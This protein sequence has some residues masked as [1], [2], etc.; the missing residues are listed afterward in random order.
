M[1]RV[2]QVS[3]SYA[4]SML[5][6]VLRSIILNNSDAAIILNNA[7]KNISIFIAQMQQHS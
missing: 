4:F 6:A 1:R 3:P 2:S 5:Y 7:I